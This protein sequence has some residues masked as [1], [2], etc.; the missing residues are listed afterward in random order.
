M[1]ILDPAI[2]KIEWSRH[3]TEIEVGFRFSFSEDD[4]PALDSWTLGRIVLVV[5][6]EEIDPLTR[7]IMDKFWSKIREKIYE[8]VDE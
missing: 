5:A 7:A 2:N 8:E 4:N 1:K 6:N 3:G